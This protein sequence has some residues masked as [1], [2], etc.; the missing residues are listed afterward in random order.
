MKSVLLIWI[1][2]T[3][4]T[5]YGQSADDLKRLEEFK[6]IVNTPVVFPVNDKFKFKIAKD[7]VYNQK[8]DTSKKLDI[9]Q[10]DGVSKN[11]K[12][13]LII[14]IHGKT[15]IETNPKN[16]GGY[17]S[18]AKLMA[19]QGYVAA[20]FTH[21]LAIPGKSIEDAASDLDAALDYIKANQSLY[22]IDTNKIALLAYSAGV[23]LLSYALIHKQSNI[24]CLVAFYGF[25]DMKNIDLWKNES[26][27]TAAKFSLINYSGSDKKFPPLFIA[28]AG[29]EHNKGLNETIDSF[30]LKANTNNLNI[31]LINHPAGV[32]GFDTQNND[33][34]SREIIESMLLFLHY[35]L[36]NS[37]LD[38]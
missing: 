38:K 32:H 11:K 23:P 14:F 37:N 33:E 17:K 29:K 36:Y 15:P 8:K 10:P 4:A 30:M 3:A 18:W 21:S 7:L 19:S 20:V 6:K 28:R 12:L 2:L 22:N 31:T 5:V 35:H 1:T 34:R 16:W 24:K 26:Q 25:L 13:P 9:Y 27:Q